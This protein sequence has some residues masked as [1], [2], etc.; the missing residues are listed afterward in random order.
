MTSH[1]RYDFPVVSLSKPKRPK[2]GEEWQETIY[3]AKDRDWKKGE[4]G[5][6]FGTVKMTHADE[7]DP[8]SVTTQFTFDDG[9]TV[10]Y[11]GKVPGNGF[12]KGK[13]RHRF[14]EGIGKFEG[15]D[16]EIEVESVNPKRWG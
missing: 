1:L 10:T 3:D 16:D 9:D 2:R 8:K 14:R 7:E 6:K 5:E 4:H 15:R 12:W 11:E 13:E